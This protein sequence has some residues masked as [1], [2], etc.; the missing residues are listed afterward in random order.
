MI[1]LERKMIKL[2]GFILLL[3]LASCNRIFEYRDITRNLDSYPQGYAYVYV[4]GKKNPYG[5]LFSERES[6]MGEI[7]NYHKSKIE[8]KEAINQYVPACA[9]FGINPKNKIYIIDSTFTPD[10]AKI[11]VMNAH[12]DFFIGYIYSAFLQKNPPIGL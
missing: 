6:C 3:L 11:G 4:E 5:P 2:S 10:L 12:N 1:S 9:L 7:V 8:N